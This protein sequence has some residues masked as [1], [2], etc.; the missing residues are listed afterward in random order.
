LK[1]LC[2][3][4]YMII[5]VDQASCFVL[6]VLAGAVLSKRRWA[7]VNVGLLLRL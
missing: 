7:T 2:I 3:L 4:S 1:Y 6:L 5:I